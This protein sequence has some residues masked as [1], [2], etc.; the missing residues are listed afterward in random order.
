M[1]GMTISPF[2][3]SCTATGG[4]LEALNKA[5]SEIADHPA[6]ASAKNL[7]TQ[8]GNDEKDGLIGVALAREN[9][10]LGLAVRD[11]L[12]A[13]ATINVERF[14]SMK[15]IRA[16]AW[17]L[18][19]HAMDAMEYQ[20]SPAAGTAVRRDT[21]SRKRTDVEVAAANLRADVFATVMS[22][23]QGSNEAVTRLAKTARRG[24]HERKYRPP[25]GTLPLC[26]RGGIDRD[27]T[28]PD[29]TKIDVE[30]KMDGRS[31]ADGAPGREDG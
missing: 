17:N 14:D 28:R 8:T 31:P 21:V 20:K 19:W 29:K 23:F 11:S 4:A 5:A 1:T 12:L 24:R 7:L 3:L 10:F 16:H 15:D 18:V 9:L 30:E 25:P 26:H 6:A 2:I 13:L 27:S 22:A